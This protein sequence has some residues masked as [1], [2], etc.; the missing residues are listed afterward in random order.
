MN[1]ITVQR[2][3]WQ[4]TSLLSDHLKCYELFTCWQ[5]TGFLGRSAISWH[6]FEP[7]GIWMKTNL[8]LDRSAKTSQCWFSCQQ[9]GSGLLG[10]SMILALFRAAWPSNQSG[11]LDR[12]ISSIVYFECQFASCLLKS[13][14]QCLC[15]SNVLRRHWTSRQVSE[16]VVLFQ[17]G[18][19]SNQ[20]YFNPTFLV[21]NS[22]LTGQQCK[23][24]TNILAGQRRLVIVS[25][26]LMF[27]RSRLQSNSNWQVTPSSANPN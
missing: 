12:S 20:P 18:W 17:A 24:L 10:R 11:N 9:H 14:W 25:S 1:E 27:Q 19:F 22:C 21:S 2:V 8:F 16:V 7:L 4:V 13:S 3:S 26:R 5:G 23:V 15:A 6:Y